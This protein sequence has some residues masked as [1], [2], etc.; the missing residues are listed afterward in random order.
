M[1]N[2]QL[3]RKYSKAMF[4]IAQDEKK[5]D[6]YGE[7]LASVKKDFASAPQ[8][9]GYLANPQIQRSDKKQLLGK[10]F[11][12]EISDTMLH[13]LYLLVDKRR[14]ELFDAIEEIYRA[15]ANEA[16]GIIVA[17][18]TSAQPL[19]GAQQESI[20]AKLSQVTGRTV[21]LRLHE[22]ASLIGGVVVRMGDK[23]IDGSVQG[24]LQKLTAELLA[25]N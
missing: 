5:L 14:I 2:L 8:L 20:K 13:F 7:E 11:Q 25:N 24:R 3:A 18:V 4:E 12:G 9:K 16:R 6:A 21:E 22:D 23:R 1:L 15:L 19:T 17:D 10:L